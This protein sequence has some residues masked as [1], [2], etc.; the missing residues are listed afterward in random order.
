MSVCVGKWRAET[1]TVFFWRLK[2]ATNNIFTSTI[3]HMMS[4]GSLKE[5]Y[6]PAAIPL[7]SADRFKVFE[8]I[9][10]IFRLTLLP[11]QSTA[12]IGLFPATAGSSFKQQKG[13]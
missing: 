1:C 10:L 6:P 5:I 13:A 12:L 7:S 11:F 8:A 3:D 2:A 9:V 4:T